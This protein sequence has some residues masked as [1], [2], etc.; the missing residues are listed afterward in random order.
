LQLLVVEFVGAI[1]KAGRP[2]VKDAMLIWVNV[3][4]FGGVIALGTVS[5]RLDA[6]TFGTHRR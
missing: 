6:L 3:F 1:L 4:A 2:F 5:G